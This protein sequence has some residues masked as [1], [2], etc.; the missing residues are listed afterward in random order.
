MRDE[1]KVD[2]LISQYEVTLF[3]Q[4][5]KDLCIT[6]IN[7]EHD[8]YIDI[9]IGKLF[10]LSNFA[11]GPN[12]LYEKIEV[13][14]DFLLSVK[15]AF[16]ICNSTSIPN[17]LGYNDTMLRQEAEEKLLGRKIS[18]IYFE[19]D[20]SIRLLLD[21]DEVCMVILPEWSLSRPGTEEDQINI[22][23]ASRVKKVRVRRRWSNNY[24]KF[25]D[26]WHT[27]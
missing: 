4:Q 20:N 22:T 12:G 14:S 11:E 24:A 17:K 15:S 9:G 10:A 21:N 3:L 19:E 18:N 6:Q 1:Q 27:F 16:L 2:Y 7:M 23:M 5:L 13:V 25:R 26:K 8:E